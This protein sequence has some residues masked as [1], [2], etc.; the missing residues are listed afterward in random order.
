MAPKRWP[1]LA[2]MFFAQATAGGDTPFLWSKHGDEYRPQSWRQ[3]AHEVSALSR[4]LRAAGVKSGDRVALVSENRPNW[5]IADLAILS[6]GAVTVPGYTTNTVDDHKHI[7]GDSGATA[8]IISGPAMAERALPAAHDTAG[9]DLVI[10]MDPVEDNLG[11][12]ITAWD[13]M[14]ASGAATGDDVGQIVG[15]ITK[16]DLACLIYTSG[17]GGRPK[18]VMLSHAAI[19]ANLWGAYGLL[20]ELGLDDEIFLSFL[21]LSHSY[22]HTAGLFFPISL[23]A[24]IYYAERTETLTTNLL[25]ARPTFMTCVPRLYETMRARILGGVN[26]TS[27]LKRKLFEAALSLGTKRYHDPDSLGLGERLLDHVVERLVREKVRGRFGGRLKAL[28]SGGAPLNEDVGLF[29]LALG[30]PILQGY[31][32]TESAPVISVNRPEMNDVSTVGPPL[33]G[34]EVK[35]AEDGEILVRGE[36]VMDGYWNAP[37]ATA[38]ALIDGWL[39]T[40]DIGELDARGRIRI[41]DRKKDIIVNSGGDNLSPQRVEGVLMLEP[42]IAQAMVYG[43][44]RP[45]LVALIVPD[46]ET[47]KAHHGDAE[48][49]TKAVAEAVA[50]ASAGLSP[51]ETVKRFALAAEPFTIDNGEMTPT[52]K[53]RRHAIIA[54]YGE[55]LDGLY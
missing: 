42:E 53:T 30:L 37:E 13:D 33:D 54:R 48:G 7:F 35:I 22:E 4:G 19:A 25:E 32:Q 43:D 27:G 1:N 9:L 50:R 3:V 49:L 55:M 36:L 52:M 18:G 15:A 2:A 24:Q 46:D 29:F 26:R 28:V 21:P 39:H 8:L 12:T 23:G 5:A 38:G 44:R 14:V 31:G 10:S 16:G 47:V 41:T 51:I 6:A 45:H 11:M 20:K 40:G 17:T 34:V